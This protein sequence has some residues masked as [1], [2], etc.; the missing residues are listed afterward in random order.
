MGLLDYTVFGGDSRRKMMQGILG[1]QAG[2]NFS[3]AGPIQPT[4]GTGLMGGQISPQQAAGQLYAIPGSEYDPLANSM[5]RGVNQENL[6]QKR[7]DLLR[8]RPIST[9]GGPSNVQ[10]Y[11]YYKNLPS[12]ADREEFLKTMRGPQMLDIGTGY[13]DT[14]TG[15]VV[16]KQIIEA[17][18][19]KTI[20][21]DTGKRLAGFQ[22]DLNTADALISGVQETK[23]Q[24]A[25]LSG[26]TDYGTTG[27][28]SYLNVIP[29]TDQKQWENVKTTVLSRLGLDKLLQ[30]KASS[31]TG[32]SGFGQLS[33]KELDLL[34]S[35]MG[36]LDQAS[37]PGEIKRII[38]SIIR[39][40]DGVEGG[41]QKKRDQQVEFYQKNKKYMP[42]SMQIDPT[43]KPTPPSDVIDWG[44]L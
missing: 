24:L 43:A 22:N 21:P 27:F 14:A 41:Y 20:A 42:E 30:M 7:E 39:Q 44:D 17:G 34:V 28:L 10:T 1:Q 25:R 11:E 15:D 29:T 12:D 5:L 16:R 26:M 4:P 8:D 18:I 6:A 19:K 40:L 2:P 9:G 38:T 36:K 3:Q 32:A 37:D 23:S 31:P 33:E 13:Y 35:N